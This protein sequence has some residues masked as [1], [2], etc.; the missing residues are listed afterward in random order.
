M[1]NRRLIILIN[2]RTNTSM[3]ASR[4]AALKVTPLKM[5]DSEIR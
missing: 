5:C 3:D 4:V 1:T 2:R